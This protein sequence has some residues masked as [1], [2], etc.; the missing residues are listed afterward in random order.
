MLD[1]GDVRESARVTINGQAAANLWCVPYRAAVGKFLKPGN[2]RLTIDVTNLSANRIRD[3]D[4]RKVEWKIF[5]EINFVD[6]HY[7]PFDASQWPLTPSGLLGPV[8][9]VPMKQQSQDPLRH[10]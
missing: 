6:I 5:D 1:L 8:R 2:N 3:L 10:E 9:C 4:Q 7:K